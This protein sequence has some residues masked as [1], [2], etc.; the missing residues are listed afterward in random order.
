MET[1]KAKRWHVLAAQYR[2]LMR[3]DDGAVTKFFAE[4]YETMA[5][6]EEAREYGRRIAAGGSV[7]K[8]QQP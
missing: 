4:G 2:D 3:W 1:A 6:L 5:R 7:A 8:T